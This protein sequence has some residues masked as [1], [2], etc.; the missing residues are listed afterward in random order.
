MTGVQTCALPILVLGTL[1]GMVCDGAKESCSLKTGGSALTAWEAAEAAGQGVTVPRGTGLAAS[2]FPEL[3]AVIGLVHRR[4]LA[5]FDRTM[6]EI[7]E[8][9]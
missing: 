9:R 6:I 4:G 7:L 8:K 1:A 5:G 2:S 3:L